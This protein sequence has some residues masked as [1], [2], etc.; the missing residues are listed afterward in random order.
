MQFDEA[1]IRLE[2]RIKAYTAAVGDLGCLLGM[3]LVCQA[4]EI[5]TTV[6]ELVSH[7]KLV[8]VELS[9]GMTTLLQ[10]VAG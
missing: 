10:S 2:S 6:N 7:T 1:K 3:R 8:H 4:S 9:S 5:Q